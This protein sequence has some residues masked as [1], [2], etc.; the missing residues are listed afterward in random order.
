M[1]HD[2]VSVVLVLWLGSRIPAGSVCSLGATKRV[3]RRCPIR[4]RGWNNEM[5]IRIT[6]NLT[7]VCSFLRRPM[8]AADVLY[9]A[10]T[11]DDSALSEPAYNRFPI[12]TPDTGKPSENPI[13]HYLY[14]IYVN[15]NRK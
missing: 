14:E 2:N 9:L 5:L 8:R 7:E 6:D 1:K 3:G 10:L 4:R 12:H 13:S 11:G 15:Y